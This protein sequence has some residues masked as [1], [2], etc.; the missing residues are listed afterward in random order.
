MQLFACFTYEPYRPAGQ[1]FR[2][3]KDRD[4]ETNSIQWIIQS[5][6]SCEIY[7]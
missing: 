3:I 6:L 1:I 2:Q 5:T 4:S 7:S